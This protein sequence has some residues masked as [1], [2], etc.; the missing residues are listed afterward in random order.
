[1]RACLYMRVPP[2]IQHVC[3]QLEAVSD[4]TGLAL[5]ACYTLTQ[6]ETL[7][8]IPQEMRMWHVQLVAAVWW[9]RS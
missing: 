9:S 2:K 4:Q 7:P 5:H 8:N 1:M 3:Q 6:V